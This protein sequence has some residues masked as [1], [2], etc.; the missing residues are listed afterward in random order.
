M[1]IST[2]LGGF[3]AYNF[4]KSWDGVRLPSIN[5][6]SIYSLTIFRTLHT[7]LIT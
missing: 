1:L 3:L 4:M 7:K 5:T 2:K 6:V